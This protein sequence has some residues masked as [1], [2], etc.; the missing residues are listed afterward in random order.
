METRFVRYNHKPNATKTRPQ[1]KDDGNHKKLMW[2]LLGR[3]FAFVVLWVGNYRIYTAKIESYIP[4]NCH[5]TDHF[6]SNKL[7]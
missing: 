2:L 7:E 1:Q 5:H 3:R 6:N 4:S